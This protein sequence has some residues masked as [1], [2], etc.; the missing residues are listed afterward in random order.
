MRERMFNY[1]LITIHNENESDPNLITEIE[2]ID[3]TSKIPA[4]KFS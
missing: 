2:R 3:T 1:L 4:I